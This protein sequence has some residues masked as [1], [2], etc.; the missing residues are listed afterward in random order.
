MKKYIVINSLIG[1]LLLVSCK[2]LLKETNP[3]G[4]TAEAYYTT[5][6]GFET[7]VAG[8]YQ[9]AKWWYGQEEGLAFTE[10]GTDLWTVGQLATTATSGTA[11]ECAQLQFVAPISTLNASILREW[12][13]LYRGINLCNLGIEIGS[14]K[15]FS[16]PRVAELK[17][18]RAFYYWHVAE[19]WGDTHFSTASTNEPITKDYKTKVEVIYEQIFKDLDE[20]IENLPAAAP[21]KEGRPSKFTAKAFKARMCLT[22]GKWQEAKNLA[23]D[24]IANGGYSLTSKYLDL[25]KMEKQGSQTEVLF[26]VNFSSNASF[27][28]GYN[29]DNNPFGYSYDNGIGTRGDNGGHLMFCP[30]YQGYD[31][32]P[33]QV[34]QTA[35]FISTVMQRDVRNGRGFNR[36]FPTKFLMD[37]YNEK[38]DQRYY[39]SFQT[40]YKLNNP[41]SNVANSPYKKM[42]GKTLYKDT[43]IVID[44]NALNSNKY[45]AVDIYKYYLPDGKTNYQKNFLCPSLVKHADST[46]LTGTNTNETGNGMVNSSKD[47]FVIRLAEMYLISAEASIQLGNLSD[48]ANT[49]N[50]LRTKRAIPGKEVDMQVSAADM[51]IDFILDERAREFAGEY[52]RWFDLKRTGKLIERVQKYN[53]D[54]ADK[55]SSTHLLKPIPLAHILSITNP[56]DFPQN[57]GY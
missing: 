33:T 46:R 28:T 21:Y 8:A 3:S 37:V 27:S 30:N 16:P 56:N 40:V 7:L 25:W 44:K 13:Q 45:Y 10:A 53:P 31:T 17:F 24:V 14:S 20:A 36:H 55:I 35:S 54:I 42:I 41:K 47:V 39:G 38:I 18:L 11:G 1:I 4:L 22:R 26:A 6:I 52:L 9:P 19:S 5:A 23:D 29:K 48:A 15:G 50:I 57:P 32:I 12:T 2:K 34:S 51:N 49:V 43:A